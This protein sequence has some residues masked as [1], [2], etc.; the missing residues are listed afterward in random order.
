[1]SQKPFYV[2]SCIWLNLWK[3]EGDATKGVP[4]WKIAKDFIERVIFSEH[5]EIIYSG[6]I[7]KE[8][9]YKLDENTFNEK[10][11]FFQNEPP[12]TEVRGICG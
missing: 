6:F 4:Y 5:E 12:R 8:L 11:L 9:K 2:D 1:M 3:K 10:L 7:L